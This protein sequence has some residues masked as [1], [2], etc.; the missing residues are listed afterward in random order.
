MEATAAVALV[1]RVE[2]VLVV[3][4]GAASLVCRTVPNR[5]RP[6]HLCCL[7]LVVVV[8]ATVAGR[9]ILKQAF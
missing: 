6:P 1:V 7:S 9:A 5:N 4:A 8:V 3:L 2:Q